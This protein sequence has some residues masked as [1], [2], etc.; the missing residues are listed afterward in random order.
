[1][2]AYTSTH[3]NRNGLLTKACGLNSEH[4]ETHVLPKLSTENGYTY[5]VT[6]EATCIEIGKAKFIYTIDEKTFE[7]EVDLPKTEHKHT[8]VRGAKTAT[9]NEE[10][11]TGDVYCKDCGTL[12][13]KGRAIEKP[14]HHDFE[15]GVCKICGTPDGSIDNDEIKVTVNVETDGN[16]LVYVIDLTSK[17][18]P[19]E[20][21]ANLK[22]VFENAAHDNASIKVIFGKVTIF[23]NKNATKLINNTSEIPLSII[24]VTDK[25]E[26]SGDYA[27][28]GFDLNNSQIYKISLGK[29]TFEGEEVTVSIQYGTDG[30]EIKVYYVDKDGNDMPP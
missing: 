4:K 27:K 29:A 15:N 26:T 3:C 14:K 2:D 19:T 17:K 16:E 18:N 8:E 7:F 25:S 20:I 28:A 24:K 6:K 11:Y 22:T 10:R 23:F 1:M 13:E 9:C 30:K 12:L 21:L 5:S